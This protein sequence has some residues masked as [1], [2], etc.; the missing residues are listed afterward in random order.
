MVIYS[1]KN[2]LEKYN[3]L[4]KKKQ[5]LKLE[6]KVHDVIKLVDFWLTIYIAY[7]WKID[8]LFSLPFL[9]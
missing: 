8:I 3:L 1:L 4:E 9:L 7:V 6:V 2:S 5:T